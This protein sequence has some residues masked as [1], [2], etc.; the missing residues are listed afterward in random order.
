[1]RILAKGILMLIAFAFIIYGMICFVGMRSG[2]E[3]GLIIQFVLCFCV[4]GLCVWGSLK[5]S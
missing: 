4:A 1:M 5:K 3:I 2:Y